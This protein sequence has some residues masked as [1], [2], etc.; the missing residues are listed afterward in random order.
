VPLV[1]LVEVCLR[2]SRGLGSLKEKSGAGVLGGLHV[3]HT[4]QREV[5]VPPQHS[6]RKVIWYYTLI[7]VVLR[8]Y[9]SKSGNV[10]RVV[11]GGM[12]AVAAEYEGKTP[13]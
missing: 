3:K 4:V 5:C 2:E 13:L 6:R 8:T 12:C 1:L 9:L 7:K 10:E 11:V